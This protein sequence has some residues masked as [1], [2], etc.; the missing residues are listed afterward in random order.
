MWYEVTIFDI[1]EKDAHQLS[2]WLEEFG[3]L[4]ITLLDQKDAPI[5]EPMPGT[6]PLW[7]EVQINALFNDEAMA[8]QCRQCL[9]D[10]YPQVPHDLRQFK[11]KEWQRVCEAQFQPQQFGPKLWVCPSWSKPVDK[12]ATNIFLDPGLAFGTGS[13][14]T[15]ALCLEWLG[16]HPPRQQS[17]LDYGCGSGILA[18]VAKKLKAST[19]TAIDIDPQA[20]EA[21]KN[22]AK[23]N[24]CF[25][26]N[27]TVEAPENIRHCFDIIVANILLGPL[28]SLNQ[29]FAELLVSKGTLVVSGLLTEQVEALKTAYQEHFRVCEEKHRDEWALLVFEKK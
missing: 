25:D 18:I 3:A 26:A 10:Q 29:R 16:T 17:L 8:K 15:T 27:F 24:H 5:L 14:P 9:T 1:P 2:E 28:Q 21:T 22:N 6:A 13:H 23:E 12:D 11:D 20:L 19:V 4:A 7:P